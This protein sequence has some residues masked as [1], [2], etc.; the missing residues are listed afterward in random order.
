MSKSCCRIRS[1]VSRG[2]LLD[3]GPNEPMDPS[4]SAALCRQVMGNVRFHSRKALG[5]SSGPAE[6]Q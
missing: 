4:G 2:A 1:L 6:W 5:P 3:S